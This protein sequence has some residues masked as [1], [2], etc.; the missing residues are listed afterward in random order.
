MMIPQAHEPVS[1]PVAGRAFPLTP[2]VASI[3]GHVFI[4][5][6]ALQIGVSGFSPPQPEA[7]IVDLVIQKSG[8]G[9]EK[10]TTSE[11][12]AIAAPRVKK[13][14]AK[15]LIGQVTEPAPAKKGKTVATAGR[16][17]EMPA[18]DFEARIPAILT[19]STSIVEPAPVVQEP[20]KKPASAKNRPPLEPVGNRLEK[21]PEIKKILPVI[22]RKNPRPKPEKK[23]AIKNIKRKKLIASRASPPGR[24]RKQKGRTRNIQTQGVRY[25]GAGLSNPRPRYPPSA[26]RN[27]VQGRVL[28][29]VVVTTSGRAGSV[30][31]RRSSGYQ[32]LDQAALKTVKRWR[33]RPATRNGKPVSARVI[34]PITFKLK[35]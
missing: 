23:R 28:L 24:G 27:R 1:T 33:F 10:E 5:A 16:G 32:L 19:A 11:P 8:A 14:T 34:V 20:L 25:S 35:G 18:E 9:S 21:S 29:A 17:A 2:L 13:T 26:R 15:P 31:I 12:K 30:R 3:I 4:G 6:G 22:V 7:I